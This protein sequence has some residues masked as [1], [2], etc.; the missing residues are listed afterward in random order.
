MG[1]DEPK[2]GN[3]LGEDSAGEFGTVV[4]PVMVPMLISVVGSLIAIFHFVFIDIRAHRRLTDMDRILLPP[5]IMERLMGTMQIR[6]DA[7]SDRARSTTSSA[8][9]DADL[10]CVAKMMRAR[11]VPRIPLCATIPRVTFGC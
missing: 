3:E 2:C 6:K 1:Y 8:Y 10:K 9:N 4:Q 11:C 7:D 5:S